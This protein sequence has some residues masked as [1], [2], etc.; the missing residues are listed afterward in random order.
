ML[1]GSNVRNG[2][3]GGISHIEDIIQ[4][5]KEIQAIIQVEEQRQS[6]EEAISYLQDFKDGKLFGRLVK[7]LKEKD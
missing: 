7:E 1:N 5:L 6:L 3:E 2:A 4:N